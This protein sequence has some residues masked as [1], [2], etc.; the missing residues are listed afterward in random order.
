MEKII[1]NG[2][3]I[4]QCILNDIKQTEYNKKK[5]VQIKYN[6]EVLDLSLLEAVIEKK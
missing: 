2:I 5:E 6:G 1:L 3:A 4:S